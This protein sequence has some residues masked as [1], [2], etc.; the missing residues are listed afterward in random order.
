[1]NYFN[2]SIS[3]LFDPL[4]LFF[5]FVILLVSIPSAIYSIGYLKDHYSSGKIMLGWLLFAAFVLS[6]ALVVTVG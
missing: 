2:A 1:M 5:I 6:M 4:S 3:L